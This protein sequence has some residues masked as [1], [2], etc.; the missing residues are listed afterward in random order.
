MNIYV[1]R[2][3]KYIEAKVSDCGASIETGFLDEHQAQEF[4][5]VLESATE[6]FRDYIKEQS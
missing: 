6:E 5:D 2:Y 4:L 1:R 3:D